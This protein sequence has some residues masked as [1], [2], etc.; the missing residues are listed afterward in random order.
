MHFENI[1]HHVVH[2]V[3]LMQNVRQVMLELGQRLLAAF[4]QHDFRKADHARQRVFQV[5]HDHADE[6]FAHLLQLLFL[7]NIMQHEHVADDFFPLAQDRIAGN[8]QDFRRRDQAQFFDNRAL[9]LGNHP[10]HALFHG[11]KLFQ[12]IFLAVNKFNQRLIVERRRVNLEQA[13][14]DRVGQNNLEFFVGHQNAVAGRIDERFDAPFFF[15]DVP[16]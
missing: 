2:G 4:R 13:I 3:G 16:E 12:I 14:D 9:R 7:R 5:M 10:V 6:I 8:F 1:I 11:I 15:D